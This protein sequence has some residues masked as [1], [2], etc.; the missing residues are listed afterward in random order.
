[1]DR[2]VARGAPRSRNRPARSGKVD[3]APDHAHHRE[4]AAERDHLAEP[5]SDS[6]SAA[7]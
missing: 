6:S 7:A 4:R 1:V 2:E 5:R 3:L